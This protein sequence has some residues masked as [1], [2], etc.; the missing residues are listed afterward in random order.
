VGDAADPEQ[1]P[2]SV[3]DRLRW[4]IRFGREGT[5]RRNWVSS[6]ATG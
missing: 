3:V 2:C 1:R 4:A 6:S 5:D